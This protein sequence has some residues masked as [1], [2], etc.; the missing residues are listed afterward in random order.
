MGLSSQLAPSAIARPGV[1]ANAAARPASPYDGQVIYETDTD[2][3]LV[4]NGT[5]WVYLSTS[6]AYTVG[7]QHIRTSVLSGATNYDINGIFSSEFRNYRIVY[8]AYADQQFN[9][10]WMQFLN[11]SGTAAGVGYYGSIY[12][13][14]FTTASTAFQTATATTVLYLGWITNAGANSYTLS[15]AIDIFHPY[16]AAPTNVSGLFTGIRSGSAFLGGQAMGMHTGA[17]VFTGIKIHNSLGG[18]M[19]A[20]INVYG[21]KD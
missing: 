14:D 5:A 13:Q 2:K 10:M 15:G 1:V 7:L 9:T 3:T 20:R 21:Y 12:G 19:V 18:T 16:V 4:W 11:S 8:E 17:D 6:S